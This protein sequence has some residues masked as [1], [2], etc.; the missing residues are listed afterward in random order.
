MKTGQIIY[1]NDE[2]GY[3]FI[4]DD[5]L[6]PDQFF[7]FSNVVGSTLTLVAGKRVSFGVEFDQQRGKEK[8]VAVTVL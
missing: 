5:G 2:K 8:A 4:R 6:G 1:C 7:H 3:G